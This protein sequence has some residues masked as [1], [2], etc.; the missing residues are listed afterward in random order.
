MKRFLLAVV[1]ILV[2]SGVSF[3]EVWIPTIHTVEN[4]NS[5][6]VTYIVGLQVDIEVGGITSISDTNVIG[7]ICQV[8]P[9]DEGL[10]V[11]TP[12]EH[13]D[14][15]MLAQLGGNKI[16]DTH[17]LD[18]SH[19]SKSGATIIVSENG[20]GQHGWGE[21]CDETN[22]AQISEPNL[23]GGIA[24][25]GNLDL[26]H[27]TT[28]AICDAP[29]DLS[30]IE[31]VQVVMP[32]GGACTITGRCTNPYA[33]GE[34]KPMIDYEIQVGNVISLSNPPSMKLFMAGEEVYDSTA[35]P[36]PSTIVMLILG[37]LFLVGV[38]LRRK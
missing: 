11:E 22:P 35:V 32:Y 30:H 20:P 34:A 5:H 19:Y 15:N 25:L 28:I 17:L 1:L 36:E 33:A 31:F 16:L 4:N 27:L 29:Q 14:N 12:L 2:I 13:E 21:S 24:G 6:V 26:L 23:N 10:Y 3:A 37:G 18:L 7:N 38:R 8:F 9:L